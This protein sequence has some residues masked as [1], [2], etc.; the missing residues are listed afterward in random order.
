MSLC[1]CSLHSALLCFAGDWRS[2]RLV[3]IE[4]NEIFIYIFLFSSF[5]LAVR[6]CV[7]TIRSN[8]D[9][10]R[11]VVFAKSLVAEVA[12]SAVEVVSIISTCSSLLISFVLYSSKNEQGFVH[13][14]WV[15]LTA[16][17]PC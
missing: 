17:W 12:N 15:G 9:Q 5:L 6:R 2:L 3:D 14:G 4:Q 10:L 1:V 16:T 7:Q 8:V 13:K 11:T